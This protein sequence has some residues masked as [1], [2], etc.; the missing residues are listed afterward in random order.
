MVYSK[1]SRISQSQ[2]MRFHIVALPHTKTSKEYNACAY[3]QKVLNFCLMMKNLGHTVY[4]YGNEGS[5]VA[6]DEHVT[7]MSE[8]MRQSFFGGNDWKKDFFAIEWDNNLPYWMYANVRAAYEIKKRMQK[9]DFLC[10]IGGWCQKPIA[11]ALGADIMP[12]EYGIGYQGVF[13]KYRVFE[14]YSHMSKIYGVKGYDTNGQFYDAVIPNYYDP[15]DFPFSNTKDDYFLFIGRLVSRKGI[16]V[17]IDT[18]KHLGKKLVIAG[19]GARKVE[20]GR[21]VCDEMTLVGDHIEYVGYAD[22]KKRGELMAKA[23]AVF[24]P[25]YYVEPFGGVAVE[26]QLCGTPVIT[27]DWGSFPEIVQHGVTGYRC[28]TLSQFVQAA[29]KTIERRNSPGYHE[30]IMR[31][32]IANYGIYKVAQMYDTYF[33]MLADLW[34]EGWYNIREDESLEWLTKTV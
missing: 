3:T 26:A 27:T 19:Q 24:V 22:V 34:G 11:D 10:L 18:T 7:I 15:A 2:T 6:C 21:I 23:T 5:D 1:L 28:R 9:G 12:V 32:A 25:T 20:P 30:N 14:S 13:S 4:H 17:A 33:R 16:Q 29:K 31:I 8:K